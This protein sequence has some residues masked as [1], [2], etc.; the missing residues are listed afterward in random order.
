MFF[1]GESEPFT[2]L[3]ELIHSVI[4]ALS[5]CVGQHRAQFT[6]KCFHKFVSPNALCLSGAMGLLITLL[7]LL[8]GFSQFLCCL[9]HTKKDSYNSSLSP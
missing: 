8:R 1:F 5:D 6:T 3:V 9:T 7:V 2:E 4:E